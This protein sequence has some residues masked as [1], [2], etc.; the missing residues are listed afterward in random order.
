[1]LLL[2]DEIGQREGGIKRGLLNAF[3]RPVQGRHKCLRHVITAVSSTINIP[4]W[5]HCGS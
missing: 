5:H 1:V 2:C 3:Q 4:A